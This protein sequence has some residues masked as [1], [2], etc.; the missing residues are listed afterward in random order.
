MRRD[1]I[2]RPLS[3][4]AIELTAERLRVMAEPNRIALL[5][6]L[7]EGEGSVQE[8]ADRVGLPHQNASH[9]LGILW[10]A[11]VLV[12]SRESSTT[13]YEIADW[14]ACWVIEQ[15]ADEVGDG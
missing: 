7:R 8:L 9:H 11:G 15:I 4:R 13:T 1:P 10:R 3:E 5:E 12:R 6:A 2:S 14:S